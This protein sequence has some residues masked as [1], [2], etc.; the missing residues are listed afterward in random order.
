VLSEKVPAAVVL[1]L[2]GIGLFVMIVFEL[3]NPPVDWLNVL[4]GAAFL[5]IVII[6]SY[7]WL[8]WFMRRLGGAR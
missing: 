7:A 5:P 4:F 6:G 3:A 8:A 1:A 2:F